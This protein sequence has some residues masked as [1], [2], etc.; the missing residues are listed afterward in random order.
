MRLAL[1]GLDQAVAR[2]RPHHVD[3]LE[4]PAGAEVAQPGIGDPSLPRHLERPQRRQVANDL[5][6]TVREP[7]ARI[8]VQLEVLE[9]RH[10]CQVPEPVVGELAGAAK[11]QRDD[12]IEP[13]DASHDRVRHL[14]AGVDGRDPAFLHRLDQLVPLAI[15]DHPPRRDDA[16]FRIDRERG[17][18]C[19][20]RAAGPRERRPARVPGVLR[21]ERSSLP[22]AQHA[23]LSPG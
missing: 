11:P 6:A 12:M 19:R 21:H 17:H 16:V 20:T 13:A 9:L 3:A 4:Q 7:S 22:L 14:A 18:A 8:L 5:E 23:R 15:L 10:V 1:H 2:H